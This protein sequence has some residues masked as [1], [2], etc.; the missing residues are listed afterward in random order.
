MF[1]IGGRKIIM[2]PERIEYDFDKP[3]TYVIRVFGFIDQSWSE[4]F[5]GMRINTESQGDQGL[6]TTLAGSL[7]D[8]AALSGVLETLYDSHFKLL[9]V[10]TLK[11]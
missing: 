3:G 5:S 6:I 10:E 2:P 11:Y 8:Q 7:P 4:R 1:G 9:S